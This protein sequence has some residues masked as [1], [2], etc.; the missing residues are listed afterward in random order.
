MIKNKDGTLFRISRPNPMLSNQDLWEDGSKFILHNFNVKE[1]VVDYPRIED[2]EPIE[3]KVPIKETPIPGMK[4]KPRKEDI[5]L[6]YCMP[7]IISMNVDRIYGES[8]PTISYGPQFKFEIVVKARED[9]S[10]QLW[11]NLL[12]KIERQSII[13]I[14][15]Q[16]RWWSV[17]Q[18]VTVEDGI[19][20]NCV[21]SSTQPSF[22]T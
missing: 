4:L 11:T 16:R 19:L 14:P 9:L 7:S 8:R 2:I 12:D 18:I 6:A 22:A 1:E 15:S 5:G 21:P 3:I 13:Y 20:L 10:I 17:Q